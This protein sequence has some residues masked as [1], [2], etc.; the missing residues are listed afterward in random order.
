MT[1]LGAALLAGALL[2]GALLGGCGEAPSGRAVEPPLDPDTLATQW[3]FSQSQFRRVLR[4]GPLPPH[5]GDPTNRFERSDAAAELGHHLFFDERLSG[6]GTLSCATCHQPEFDF[7]DRLAVAEGLGPGTRN[8]PT[9]LDAFRQ[10]WLTWDGRADSMWSQALQPIERPHEMGGSRSAAVRRLGEDRLL[11][12]LYEQAFGALPSAAWLAALPSR[13]HPGDDPEASAAWRGLAPEDRDTID[14][15]FANLGKALAA[16]QARLSGGETP[17]DRF[18]DAWRR[19]DH[20]GIAAYPEAAREGLRLFSGPAG[21]FQCHGGPL[22]SDGE[23]H[24]VGMPGPGGGRPTDPG[25][26]LGVSI[27]LDD[28]FNAAGPHSDD[29]QGSAALLT[30][31]AAR[32]PEFWGRFRT[33]SLRQV[34][35]TAPYMHAGQLP[36]L[37]SVIR[38]YS[39]LEG[40]VFLD[41]HAETVLAPLG[42]ADAEVT[43][44]VAFLETLTGPGPPEALRRPPSDSP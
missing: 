22:L 5:R 43:A 40:S 2:A 23:F 6:S 37:E 16:Y 35:R 14:R 42:L 32:S 28:P 3:G 10:R 44:L 39:T 15:V 29:P 21:C 18:L 25:R 24:S 31:R 30:A 38:F 4:M 34:D 8:T 11:A 12:A 9:V 7:T 13:A 41:H 33:P 1:L 17:F 27:L 19:G 36:D 26:Y 20:A